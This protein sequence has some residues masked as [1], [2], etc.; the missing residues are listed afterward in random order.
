MGRRGRRAH[1]S[2]G[3]QARLQGI[4][5][6]AR[7][8]PARH[9]VQSRRHGKQGRHLPFKTG[10]TERQGHLR[11]RRQRQNPER[12]QLSP[13]VPARVERRVQG[14]RGQIRQR[15]A[16]RHPRLARADAAAQRRG[17]RHSLQSA[18][19]NG[20]P[21]RTSARKR[22][23]PLQDKSKPPLCSNG[24]LYVAR[25]KITSARVRPNATPDAE[26]RPA[27]RAQRTCGLCPTQFSTRTESRRHTAF[28][29][30]ECVPN[31]ARSCLSRRAPK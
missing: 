17:E 11:S 30:T 20:R 5:R 8:T 2:A 3:K 10:G 18:S 21:Q 16:D 23:R 9:G 25:G 4:Q 29:P 12:L 22:R 31:T 13:P 27:L 19:G 1:F 7:A 26:C 6:R 14:R 28:F 15:H 24:G